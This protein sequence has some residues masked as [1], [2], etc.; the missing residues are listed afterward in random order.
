MTTYVFELCNIYIPEDT[1]YQND[2]LNIRIEPRDI[3]EE[4]E[5]ERRDPGSQYRHG[6]WHTAQCYI[7]AEEDR[8]KQLAHWLTLIYS[9]AQLR[10]VIWSAYYT[11]EQD[12][13]HRQSTYTF[14]IDNSNIRLIKGVWGSP[15]SQDIGEFV[16]TALQT[17]D[18]VSDEE[19]SHLLRSLSLFL[20]ASS[21]TF[22]MIKFLFHWIVLESNANYNYDDY[23]QGPGDPI[24]T[25]EEI[26]ALCESVITH[27]EENDW[28]SDKVA[29]MEYVLEQKHLYEASSKT[30]I[31]I[32]L[33]HLNIGFDI[34][35]IED[36]IQMAR[37][38]RNPIVHRIDESRLMNNNEI[39]MDIRKIGFYVIL[40]LLGVDEE[41]QDR[42]ITPMIVGP[43][44]QR[45]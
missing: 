22:W 18:E 42:L 31:K 8:A 40:R 35:E 29:H 9:F 34:E 20:E 14:S 21:D 3:A 44:I 16:D 17:F 15:G 5:D 12:R 37:S 7:E 6:Y 4:F 24:F 1:V 41:M 45:D 27:L 10:D 25:D 2:D 28:S 43:D 38:I 13:G 23:L 11:L 30:K 19:R 39:V 33:E 32:Y 26:E 36:I